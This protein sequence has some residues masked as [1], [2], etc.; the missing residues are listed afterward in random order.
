MDTG[1]LSCKPNLELAASRLVIWTVRLVG[2]STGF[3]HL[4]LKR[5]EVNSFATVSQTVGMN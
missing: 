1:L 5:V 4:Y 2:H 3:L